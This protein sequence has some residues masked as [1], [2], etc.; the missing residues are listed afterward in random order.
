MKKLDTSPIITGVGY[1]PSKK[2]FDFLYLSNQEI[3]AAVA[4]AIGGESL[5]GTECYVLFGC[6]KTTIG[7]NT[8]SISYGYIYS[9]VDG[10]VYLYPGTGSLVA[11][12]AVIL[13]LDTTA[14]IKYP[15]TYNP[16]LFTDNTSKNVHVNNQLVASNGALN[17]GLINFDDLIFCQSYFKHTVGATGEPAYGAGFN[18][19][20]SVR[21]WKS[22]E[23]VTVLVQY[24][25]STNA[26]PSGATIFTLPVGFRPLG[27]VI[28]AGINQTSSSAS[29]AAP[30]GLHITNTGVVNMVGE[31]TNAYYYFYGSFP[32]N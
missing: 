17:S 1:P 14:G 10:E 27:D 20:G 5:T 22:K 21:F 3:L 11:A 19:A 4:Q 9:A 26:I 29:V 13:K 16:V 2:G 7:V 31:V 28:F 6:V 8:Y 15:A 30:A 12:T 24:M 25:Q 32:I 23:M 18:G